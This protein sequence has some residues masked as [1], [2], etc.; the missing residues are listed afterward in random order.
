MTASPQFAPRVVF[1]LIL[2][3]ALTIYLISLQPGYP[4]GGDSAL[5]IMHAR[6]LA[7]GQP[8][9]RTHY[10]YDAE[11]WV[12][13]GPSYPPGL[14]LLT[15]PVYLWS[16]LNLGVFRDYCAVL[17]AA[18]LIPVFFFL[19]RSLSPWFACLALALAAINRFPLGCIQSANSESPYLLFSFL[20]LGVAIWVYD[21]RRNETGPLAWGAMI[22]A[23]AAY[24]AA[25]R[26][27][28]VAL[29]G[30]IGLYDLYRNRRI[31]RFLL[32]AGLVFAA[33]FCVSNLLVHNDAAVYSNQ[34]RFNPS[35]NL[36]GVKSYALA[37]L[38]LWLG[39]PGRRWPRVILWL[40]TTSLALYGLRKAVERRGP[41]PTEFYVL[42][43]LGVLYFYWS[44]N[45][46]YLMPLTPIYFLYLFR[47][48]EA[49]W[50]RGEPQPALRCALAGLVLVMAGA[51]TGAALTIDRR[52]MRDGVHTAT[53]H[54][55]VNYIR[56]GTPEDA[57]IVSDSARFLAL[58]TDRDSLFYPIQED[59][60]AIAAFLT[61][62]R[63]NYVLV[64]KHHVDDRVKL[65]PA[66]ALGKWRLEFQN[67]EYAVYGL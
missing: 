52:P 61:R 64:S 40:L 26:S 8:Y 27:I 23:L 47:G 10:V 30:A 59:P 46:R 32:A 43:Y 2:A 50:A 39:I 24:T 9:A 44:T 17:L 57:R 65:A 56:T 63:A 21:T 29:M 41:G 58:F 33:M 6:N 11:A 25:T 34:F 37:S 62:V 36:A 1:L 15:V 66:L 7:T 45:A 54:E 53:Y 55:A 38:E 20:G 16:G 28:G 5:E 35:A 42:C 48:I 12:E 60:R 51:A 13:G 18:A 31:T 67:T 3:L 14:P 22:G 49:L 4:W 19:R